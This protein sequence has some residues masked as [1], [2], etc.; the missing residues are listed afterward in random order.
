MNCEVVLMGQFQLLSVVLPLYVCIFLLVVHS[1]A[2][3][4]LVSQVYGIVGHYDRIMFRKI[5]MNK[6]CYSC[7]LL[8]F[9]GCKV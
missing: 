7:T 3:V 8:Y 9:E 5:I 4:I 1:I 6:L 2:L